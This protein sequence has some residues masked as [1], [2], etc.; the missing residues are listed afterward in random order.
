[1]LLLEPVNAG[2]VVMVIGEELPVDEAIATTGASVMDVGAKDEGARVVGAKDE[3][4]TVV[5][6]TDDGDAVVGTKVD[7]VMDVGEGL[8][9]VEAL[10]TVVG[11]AVGEGLAV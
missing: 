5:G 7:G 11:A 2:D 4:A 8:E 10:S 6:A 1:M 3:G 9:M